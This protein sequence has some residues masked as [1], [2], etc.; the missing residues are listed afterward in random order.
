MKTLGSRISVVALMVLGA[1]LLFGPIDHTASAQD[2]DPAGKCMTCHKEKSPGLYNQ[3]Y[4]SRHAIA[5]VTCIECHQADEA[6]DDAFLHYDTYIATL[7]TP[8]DC[9]M[10][11]D[12]EME[13]V[14]GLVDLFVGEQTDVPQVRIR[15]DRER[16]AM[17]GLRPSDIDELIDVAFLGEKTSQVY[18]GEN[19]HDLVVRFA[20]QYRDDLESIRKTL[21]D[22]PTGGAIPLEMVADIRVDRGPNY[23]SRENV[24]RKIVVQANVADR[25]LRGAVEEI[26][27]VPRSIGTQPYFERF[28]SAGLSHTI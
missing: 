28:R 25:D 11:H 3:W 1:L 4:Q 26:R 2:D 19:R 14:D 12:Q 10:C 5:D 20:P 21:I 15:A 17:Y 7:V 6:D 23:I 27:D 9:G 24:Q 13:E 8:G 16:M 18:D 22:T